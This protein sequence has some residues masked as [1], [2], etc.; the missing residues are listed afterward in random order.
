MIKVDVKIKGAFFRLPNYNDVL[1][2][3]KQDLVKDMKRLGEDGYK[4]MKNLIP[5]SSISKPHLRE[6]FEVMAGMMPGADLAQVII[7]TKVPYAPFI[8]QGGSIP[9]R[10]ANKKRAMKWIGVEGSPVYRAYAKGFNITGTQYIRK[11]E[12]YMVQNIHRYIDRT[13][14]KHLKRMAG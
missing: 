2:K 5:Q 10:R 4:H 8:D 6:S 13:I 3:M 7:A 14:R 11:T 12:N 9:S 1:N